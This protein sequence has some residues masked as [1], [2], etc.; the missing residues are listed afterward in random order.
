M[1]AYQNLLFMS[2]KLTRGERPNKKNI[3]SLGLTQKVNLWR[4]N[5]YGVTLFFIGILQFLDLVWGK[6][7]LKYPLKS[8]TT[9]N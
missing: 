1:K 3:E 4:G 6:W 9:C 8:K 2:N 7:Y 5:K